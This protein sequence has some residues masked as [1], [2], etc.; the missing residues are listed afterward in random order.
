M[1]EFVESVAG[2]GGGSGCPMPSPTRW[3]PTWR[4]T[5]TRPRPK[6]A[7]PRTCSATA[8]SI[9]VGSRR[10]GPTP[11]AI[12]TPAPPVDPPTPSVDRPA[13]PVDRPAPV[14]GAPTPPVGPRRRPRAGVLLTAVFAG[15]VVL[16]GL[17]LLVARRSGSVSVAFRSVAGR[18]GGPFRIFAPGP[19]GPGVPG[20]SGRRSSGPR[21]WGR[22]ATPSPCS[23]CWWVSWDWV[24][25][26][27]CTGRRGGLGVTAPTAVR[28]HRP[29]TDR[30]E[31]PHRRPG[32]VGS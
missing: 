14:T 31:R 28:V 18:S 6:A 10:R 5:S 20:S 3:P 17:T 32:S 13:L 29:G 4:P 19:S 8:P 11:W 2:S 16:A 15:L 21:W 30:P 23:C 7:R 27:S 24:W 12:A 1:N 25:W 22:P 9:P 26:R